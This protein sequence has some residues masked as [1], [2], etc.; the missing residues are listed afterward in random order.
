MTI[1]FPYGTPIL[2]ILTPIIMSEMKKMKP[3]APSL[4]ETPAEKE[5]IEARKMV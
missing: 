4:T 5:A 2:A 1:S 3:P